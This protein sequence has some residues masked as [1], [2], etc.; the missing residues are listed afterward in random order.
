[1]KRSLIKF[2][3]LFI[4]LA[5]MPQMSS[6]ATFVG[7]GQNANS[8]TTTES[9]AKPVPN[10]C[11]RKCAIVYRRCLH[12]AGND[13]AKRKDCARRYRVCLRHCGRR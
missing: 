11:R 10:S 1:M 5:A 3:L 9:E 8:S 12:A 7:A 4:L 2:S 6:S 13:P